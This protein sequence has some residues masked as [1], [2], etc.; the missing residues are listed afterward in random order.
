MIKTIRGK[1]LVY[2]LVFLVV[3]QIVAISIF[4]SSNTI[5]KSYDQSFQRFLI[6]NNISEQAD[7]LYVYARDFVKKS[8]AAEIDEFLRMKAQLKKEEEKLLET[9]FDNQL[10]EAR[11]YINTLDTFIEG[12]ELTVGFVLLDDME[13]YTAHLEEARKTSGYI[14]DATLELLDVE[15]TAYQPTYQDLSKRTEYFFLFIVF[16]FITTT[17][18][19][20][21]FA[22]Y[23][24]KGITKPIHFLSKA[25]REVADGNLQGE[26]VQVSSNEELQ[27]LGSTFNQ[28]RTNIDHLVKEIKDQS[29]QDQ[30][31]K[32][33][34]IKQLQNQINPHFLFNTLNTLSKMAYLEDAHSTSGLIDSVAVL[35][36]HNLGDIEQSIT[37]QEELAVVEGYFHIQKTRFVERISFDIEVDDTALHQRIPR[38]TLQP[39]VENAFIHGIET[40]EEGGHIKI[41][42]YQTEDKVIAEIKDDGVG[43]SEEEV[44]SIMNLK[45]DTEHVGHSTGI[46]LIN[47][48]RRLQ[49]YY[50]RENVIHID[51]EIGKG[52]TIQLYLSKLT[53][54]S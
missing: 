1:L 39:L 52:T 35:M 13:Q 21:Y 42:I 7:D 6:L 32:E 22:F 17:L 9:V 11:N 8:E 26:P 23:F 30:L 2:F 10:I 54:E 50:Q 43:M 29:E 20:I 47:V 4:I 12:A 18:A 41:R 24:S 51:S 49:I 37:L 38:M 48:I 3:F 46:G 53:K 45:Q 16:L 28:M 33:M 5:T 34:E 36:R 31:L 44:A 27:I 25:A 40:R 19:A 15:L 14:Q